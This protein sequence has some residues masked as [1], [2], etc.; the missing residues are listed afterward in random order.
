MLVWPSFG[1]HSVLIR[2]F[3]ISSIFIFFESSVFRLCFRKSVF[4]LPSWLVSQSSFILG[5]R[6][7]FSLC[8]QVSLRCSFFVQSLFSLRSVIVQSFLSL[9]S[10][11][12]RSTSVG[13]SVSQIKLLRAF[14]KCD[15]QKAD[16]CLTDKKLPL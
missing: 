1:L 4:S 3:N 2:S 15:S 13:R 14:C 10:V 12:P 6:S 11:F 7:V 8:S 5:H 9:R 16:S